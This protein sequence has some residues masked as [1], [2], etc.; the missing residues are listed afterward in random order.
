[1]ILCD[2]LK[3]IFVQVAGFDFNLKAPSYAILILEADGVLALVLD[4]KLGLQRARV[5]QLSVKL[6]AGWIIDHHHVVDS[7]LLVP[8]R[9]L[10]FSNMILIHLLKETLGGLSWYLVV[11]LDLLRKG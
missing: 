2:F 8:W 10:D 6:S 3:L 1:M 4:C 5:R 11:E 7:L 9:D